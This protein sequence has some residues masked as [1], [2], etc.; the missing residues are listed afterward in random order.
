MMCKKLFYSISIVSLLVICTQ[1]QAEVI[2]SDDFDHAMMDDWSRINYQG[3]YEQ[4]VLGW[5]SPGGPWVI[6]N[7]D[8]YQSLPDDTGVS[9]TVL[10]AN[11]IDALGI[12]MD[13]PNQPQAWTPGFEGEILNGV[14]RFT[15]TNGFW[16]H[17]GNSGPFL[18]KLV[19]GDF[20][21]EVE[22]VSY[23]YWW[24]QVGGIM[25]RDPNPD[26]N[27][28]WTQIC[29]FPL[30]DIGNRANDTVESETAWI[31]VKGYPTEPYLRLQRMGNTFHYYTSPDG[32]TW[33]SLPGLEDGVVRDDLP[34]E[35]QVGIFHANF[36]GDWMISTDFDNFSIET[37]PEPEP[38]PEPIQ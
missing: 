7:W 29:F 18:Y 8:G 26:P 35:L 22:V 27:E 20:I 1:V 10:A 25:A 3:W 28:N 21:A 5:P 17:G 32:Q 12:G 11:Y 19:E 36:N 14:L 37:I 13:E 31:G 34:A 33:T 30:Y 23:N 24:Y 6:G 2:F 9:P 16:E 15:S 38:E 4:D